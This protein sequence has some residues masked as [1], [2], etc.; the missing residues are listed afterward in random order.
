MTNSSI[1]SGE[2]AKRVCPLVSQGADSVD[3]LGPSGFKSPAVTVDRRPGELGG[4]EL[5]EQGSV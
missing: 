5:Q 4:C 3:E 1:D 2:Q